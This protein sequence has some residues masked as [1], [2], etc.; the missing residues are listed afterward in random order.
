MTRHRAEG[1][2]SN[3]CMPAIRLDDVA[4]QPAFAPVGRVQ[5]FSWPGIQ[6]SRQRSGHGP[7]E[8]QHAVDGSSHIGTARRTGRVRSRRIFCCGV[9]TAIHRC[10]CR[11]HVVWVL[12][13]GDADAP[14]RESLGLRRG[15][16]AQGDGHSLESLRYAAVWPDTASSTSL[17]LDTAAE[18]GTGR[19]PRLPSPRL[20]RR[21][22]AFRD[23]VAAGPICM[24]R[25]AKPSVSAGVQGRAARS[26]R[27]WPLRDSGRPSKPRPS[28][29]DEPARRCT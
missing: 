11:M 17:A 28:K 1:R 12:E 22:K 23:D 21:I 26:D 5:L 20:P 16:I 8:S 10:R 18:C 19:L 15:N 25:A 27:R 29:R 14:T 24:P 2:R 4:V 9:P 6:P 7:V 13:R 3:R